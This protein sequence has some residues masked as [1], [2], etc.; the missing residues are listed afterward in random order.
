MEYSGLTSDSNMMPLQVLPFDINEIISPPYTRIQYY[1]LEENMD[2]TSR[3]IPIDIF[4]TIDIVEDIQLSENCSPEEIA[5]SICLHEEFHEEFF[6]SHEEMPNFNP[7]FVTHEIQIHDKAKW[8]GWP[9]PSLDIVVE[10]MLALRPKNN[11]YY[12]SNN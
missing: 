12:T 6:W 11:A 5:N 3:S 8:N 2:D 7:S 4:V 10:P 9:L 1:G